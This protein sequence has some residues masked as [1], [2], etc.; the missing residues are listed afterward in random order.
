MKSQETQTQDS[1]HILFVSDAFWPFVGGAENYSLILLSKLA[2]LGLKIR[3]LTHRFDGT[4]P[5]ETLRNLEIYR[6]KLSFSEQNLDFFRRI[7]FYLK[8][9]LAITRFVSKNRPNLLITQQLISIPTILASKLFRIPVLVNVHD[10][11]PI[12]YYRSILNSDERICSTFDRHFHDVYS[13]VRYHAHLSSRHLLSTP[14]IARLY[15]FFACLHTL[16]SRGMLGKA[17]I[18]V[19]VSRYLK[20][21]LASNGID[22]KK[23]RVI[24]NPI[25]ARSRSSIACENI[26]VYMPFALYVGRLEAEK[27]VEF[28]VKAAKQ[29]CAKLKEFQLLIVGDGP[30]QE[31]LQLLSRRLGIEDRVEFLGRVSDSTLDCL[32]EASGVVVVPSIWAEPFGRVVAEAMMYGRPVV[33]SR[34]GAIPEILNLKKGF[35]VPPRNPEALAN[36]IVTAISGRSSI[37][38]R[39]SL[40]FS[41]DKIAAQYLSL[42]QSVMQNS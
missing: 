33:A 25:A 24:Y 4:K 2:E 37:A 7:I 34:V 13:C 8:S 19:V 11:W 29:V 20:K 38:S 36:A 5:F 41:S 6:E 27:G 31:S 30:L 3:V 39:I 40:E 1:R 42:I 32:Y 16:I 15:S 22:S 26:S 14:T 35:L 18:I 9:F 10:Y 12:C 21:A 28:L 17:D 23:I